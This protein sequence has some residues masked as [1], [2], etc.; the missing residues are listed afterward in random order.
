MGYNFW[1]KIGDFDHCGMVVGKNLDRIFFIRV[2]K[3]G[4]LLILHIHLALSK[5]FI[6]TINT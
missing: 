5:C 4:R 6:R 1:T 2:Q 3:L